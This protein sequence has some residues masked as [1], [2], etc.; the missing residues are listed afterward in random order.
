M[1]HLKSFHVF[2]TAAACK[3]YSE[4]AIVLNITHGAVSKQIKILESYL[5]KSLFYKEGRHVFLTSDGELLKQYT[6]RAFTALNEGM[7]ALSK[8]GLSHLDISCEPT[9]TM[10]WLMPRLSSFNLEHQVDI[11]LST[12]G[13]PVSLGESGLSMAIRRDDF[14]LK[15]DYQITP[16]VNEWVGPVC[17]PHFWHSIQ[18]DLDLVRLLHSQTRPEA[19]KDW[20]KDQDDKHDVLVKQIADCLI[21]SQYQN[22]HHLAHFYFC[23]QA[24]QDGL[25]MAI[26]SYPLVQDELTRGQLIAPFGFIASGHRYIL[27]TQNKPES[28]LEQMFKNWLVTQIA[29]SK[30]Y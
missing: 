12:A 28:P 30:P 7:D 20:L 27:L 5:D 1:R 16:L 29:S 15:G 6:R 17:S 8:Q 13:G 22:T 4:A 18:N 21:T 24:A 9:L 3:S 26:G 25:G 23:L 19:W 2:H 14:E 11:R 10:R